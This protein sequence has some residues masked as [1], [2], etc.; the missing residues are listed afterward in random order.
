MEKKQQEFV[1]HI[2][3][4][5]EDFSQWYTDVILKADL[6]DYAPVKGCM[7]IKPYGYA[8]WENIQK[9]LDAR[10]KATGHKNAY[11]PLFIPESL[12]RKEAEHVEGFAPEV[13]WVTRGGSE[14]LAEPLVVRPTSETIICAM[15]AKWVQSYRDL[16]ILYNQWCNVVRWEKSTRPFLRTAEFLWQEGHTVHATEEEAEEETLKILG[17]YKE[18]A[19]NVLAIP[20]VVGRKSEKEKFAGALRTY[21]MEA[22][23]QDGKALQAG[24]SHNLGQHFAKVFD[25]QYLDRDG[26][27]KY[28][29]QTSWGVSTR[30]IGAIIMVHGD[31]RGLVL[32]PKVAPVQVVIIPIAMHKEGVLDKAREMY[33]I[34]ADAGIRVEIDDRDTQTPGWKFNE[35]ELKG[36]PIRLEIG[37]KDIEKN[38]VVLVRRD[39]FE[40]ISVPMD[41]V[42]QAINDMLVDVH[43]G[44]YDKALKMRENFTHVAHNFD[45][46]KE[47]IEVKK[48]FVKAM[49]CGER[50]C[51][52]NIKAET[53]ATTRCIPF[54]QEHIGDSCV[55]CGRPA[56]HMVY[57]A[58]AY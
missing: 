24:T 21:T 36:V 55:Y 42:V 7:V 1:T 28:A 51:E 29:W 25:I 23:M 52:D 44:I 30:L 8:I 5:E 43:K 14:E 49:W 27:L 46:F 58:R 17:I 45:E 48:G 39:S 41:G 56:K 57:F 3:P 6:V 10:F 50:E 16:P 40:K 4:R 34:I 33:K 37:P 20:V 54:E 53:G 12:L 9:E 13:A 47:A 22:M 18:F 19:E 31:E 38:Q 26:Q 2:T 35:W 32:P 15:Y 11:F